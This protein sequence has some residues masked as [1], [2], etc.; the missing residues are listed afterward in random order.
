MLLKMM[1]LKFLFHKLYI[2]FVYL[3]IVFVRRLTFELH[4]VTVR[5]LTI[6]NNKHELQ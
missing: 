1:F 4:K 2:C 3:N 5:G 6:V